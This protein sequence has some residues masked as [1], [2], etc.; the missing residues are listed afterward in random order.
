[1][2][3]VV[4]QAGRLTVRH[5]TAKRGRKPRP[6]LRPHDVT[7][8]LMISGYRQSSSRRLQSMDSEVPCSG[9]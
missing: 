4:D 3:S 7:Q 8:R 5:V 2:R 9:T 1:M 6:W